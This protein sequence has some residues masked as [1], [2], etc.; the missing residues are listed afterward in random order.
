MSSAV[1][2]FSVR[3]PVNVKT[4][5]LEL[6]WLRYASSVSGSTWALPFISPSATLNW[7]FQKPIVRGCLSG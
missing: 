1:W 7:C 5:E 6:I 2:N 3:V 4:A